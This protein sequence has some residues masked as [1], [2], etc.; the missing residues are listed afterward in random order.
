MNQKNGQHWANEGTLKPGR[1]T[2]RWSMHI[3]IRQQMKCVL[4]CI[5]DWTAAQQMLI[6]TS[7]MSEDFEFSW[8]LQLY[9]YTTYNSV[10]FKLQCAK[11]NGPKYCVL[12]DLWPIRR[13]VIGGCQ[14]LS[15]FQII[16][17]LGRGPY[18]TAWAGIA[19][20]QKAPAFWS[21]LKLVRVFC[22]VTFKFKYSLSFS[23]EINPWVEII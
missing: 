21:R 8:A 23:L 22:T 5:R 7:E 6:S 11:K 12:A 19:Q 13:W 2:L 15:E 10:H 17:K 14:K 1:C 4:S 20:V 18:A 3:S 9:F 16:P